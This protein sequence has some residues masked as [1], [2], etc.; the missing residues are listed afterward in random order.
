MAVRTTKIGNKTSTILFESL[1][2]RQYASASKLIPTTPGFIGP[3]MPGSQTT[4]DTKTQNTTSTTTTTTTT[5]SSSTTSTGSSSASTT[6]QQFALYDT[7]FDDRYN[8]SDVYPGFQQAY[9]TGNSGMHNLADPNEPYASQK[10]IDVVAGLAKNGG[11]VALSGTVVQPGTLTFLD[12]ETDESESTSY[13][14]QRLN[15]FHQADP[16]GKA[17]IWGLPIGWEGLDRDQVINPTP[18]VQ[19]QFQANIVKD[20]PIVNAMD[21]I[22]IPAYMLGPSSDAR[23][24][25][26]ITALANIYHTDFPGKTVL[27]W[28][29]GAYHT[30]WNPVN[31]VLP[32]AVT[33]AYVQTCMNC[34][35]GMVVWGPQ[36]DNNLLRETA[37]EMTTPA[38]T[39]A[40]LPPLLTMPD[41]TSSSLSIVGDVDNGLFSNQTIGSQ[42]DSVIN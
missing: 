30:S 16:G 12:F 27:A 24:L 25:Q 41:S 26:W 42:M 22:I 15:W 10:Q 31:D 20:T 17:G 5:T 19:A 6:T 13:Y 18:Q 4:T 11:T 7:S 23:D 34:C 39:D 36:E 28:T 35:D 33:Q 32:T 8:A 1:E 14:V 38:L 40:T 2:Q 9:S 21:V 37:V 3:V 29:W